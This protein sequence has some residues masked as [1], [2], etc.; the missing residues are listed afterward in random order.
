MTGYAFVRRK[1]V[2][3][4]DLLAQLRLQKAE[5]VNFLQTAATRTALA[6]AIPLAPR[7]QP[8]PL[9][10]AQERLWFLEQLQ[11]DEHTSYNMSA[12]LQLTGPLDLAALAVSFKR[13]DCTPRD[14]A[15]H[16]C[17]AR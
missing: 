17:P 4:P 14:I 8:L 3:T 15:H 9:A 7:T 10:F 2:M 6:T 16:L 12:T 1:V 5:I 11:G 13:G